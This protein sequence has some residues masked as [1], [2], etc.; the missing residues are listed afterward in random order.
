MPMSLPE[1]AAR[2]FAKRA[3]IYPVHHIGGTDVFGVIV[4]P[5]QAGSLAM[6]ADQVGLWHNVHAVTVVPMPDGLLIGYTTSPKHAER[7]LSSIGKKLQVLNDQTPFGS[8]PL[9]GGTWTCAGDAC[10]R[11]EP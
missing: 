11:M 8:K 6:I 4:D 3:N 7:A 10:L 5:R 2:A 1:Q 9:Y